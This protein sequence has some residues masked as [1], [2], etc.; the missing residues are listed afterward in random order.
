MKETKKRKAHPP[1]FKAKAGL[2][3]LSGEKTVNQIGKLKVELDRLK[4]SPAS[5]CH[6]RTIMDWSKRSAPGRRLGGAFHLL[7][8]S[9]LQL[10][11]GGMSVLTRGCALISA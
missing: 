5:A 4:K 6:D 7:W 9:N 3:D 10:K 1:E 2:E 8:K 11:P